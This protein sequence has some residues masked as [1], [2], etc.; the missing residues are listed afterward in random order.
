MIRSIFSS[1]LSGL[2]IMAINGT[3]CCTSVFAQ[4]DSTWLGG[5]GNW[6]DDSFWSTT[7]FPNNGNGGFDYNAIIGSGT[8]TLDL[9]V[10]IE[11]L[12][13]SG[14]TITGT[15]NLTL[16]AP[17]TWSG[18]MMTG[19][20]TIS[21]DSDLNLSG[22]AFK[23]IAGGR[24]IQ[25]AGTTNW[26]GGGLFFSGGSATWNNSG[27]FHGSLDG[28]I[29]SSGGTNIMNN[30]GT[31]IRDTTNGTLEV[32]TQ[33]NN[34]GNVEVHTGTLS[35]RGGGS[36]MG[37]NF[38]AASG[39]TFRFEGGH[40]FSA[41]SITGSGSAGF[42]SASIN[43]ISA[44]ST[45]DVSNTFISLGTANFDNDATTTTFTMSQSGGFTI[46]G[47]TGTFTVN[48]NATWSG[49]T[50]SDAGTTVFNGDLEISGSAGKTLTEG[51]TIQ[52]AGTTNWTGGS[53][54]FSSSNNTWNNSGTIYASLNT[55]VTSSSETNTIN[56]SGTF[57][58]DTTTGNLTIGPKFNNSGSVEVQTGTLRFVDFTQTDG[59][60]MLAGGNITAM[61][62]IPLNL[63]GGTLTGN[64]LITGSVNN[65][66]GLLSPGM[67]AGKLEITGQ[68]TMGPT[69][70]MLIELGGL[71]QGTTFDWI[72]VGGTAT[73]GGELIIEL[74]GGFVPDLSD[75]FTFLTANSV[76]G[77]F[78]SITFVGG[79]SL[80][81]VYLS[82]G[83]QLTN[84]AI[85]EPSSL[86]L[87]GLVAGLAIFRRRR[88]LGLAIL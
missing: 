23:T 5:S 88:Q 28:T 26:T 76:V 16:N 37:G 22:G 69:S 46:L 68:L 8:A 54:S 17:S 70:S 7:D 40:S 1:F 21:F 43:T 19:S 24:T 51:R 80:D 27:T 57:I 41:A 30:S 64:G 45:W 3:F 10:I 48:G 39:A 73:L 13:F 83:V 52:T 71:D 79:Q 25:T 14:G 53:I 75:T 85:P 56:N 35:L 60:L 29:S 47:G 55:T 36:S 6:S 66:G 59:E 11:A 84:V 31:F 63:Q 81:V 77:E 86:W 61:G 65:S 32:R 49:G 74:I 87:V 34:S 12:N 18:G 50:M 44:D 82:N 72:D 4:L 33:F 67:S 38:T 62:I 2:M 42:A 9:D 58:R 15:H 20:G 78:D